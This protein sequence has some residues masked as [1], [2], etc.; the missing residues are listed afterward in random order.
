MEAAAEE[1][2]KENSENVL[3][4]ISAEVSKLDLG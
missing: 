4:T 1:V 2:P 3:P